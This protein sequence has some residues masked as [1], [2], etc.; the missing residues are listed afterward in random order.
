MHTTMMTV[1]LSLNSV[2]ER[3]GCLFPG[4][5]IVSR[6]PDKTLA[7][8]TYGPWHQRTRAL[9][10]A[11]QPGHPHHGR[12][13]LPRGM[14]LLVGGAA[15][16]EAL[17][18][19]FDAHGIWLLQGWGMIESSPLAMVCYPRP[20]LADASADK[21]YRRAAMAGVPVPPLALSSAAIVRGFRT[22]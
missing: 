4:R 22:Q 20:E 8:H 2:L 11:Q 3:A 15:A 1:P 6:R 7:R 5:E 16:P 18:R 21:R 9:A 19:A 12:W 17:V 14:C 10:A 13:R